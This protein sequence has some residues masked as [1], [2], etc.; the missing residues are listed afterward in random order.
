[1]AIK[2][3]TEDFEKKVA[4]P[5][6]PIYEV[7]TVRNGRISSSTLEWSHIGSDALKAV[8]ACKNKDVRIF[9]IVGKNKFIV[10]P[11]EVVIRHSKN[12]RAS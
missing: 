7:V 2:V 11:H 5:N 12:K 1:M 4:T 9:K 3:S 10:K 6:L 8:K